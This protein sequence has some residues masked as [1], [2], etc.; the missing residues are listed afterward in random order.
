MAVWV[1]SLAGAVQLCAVCKLL[2][3]TLFPV[4]GNAL[5]A[6][7]EIR[8]DRAFECRTQLAGQPLAGFEPRMLRGLHQPRCLWAVP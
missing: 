5:H 2:R 4:G 3:V 8:A 7:V 6:Q 1:G